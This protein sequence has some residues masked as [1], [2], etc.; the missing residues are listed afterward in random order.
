MKHRILYLPIIEQGLVH[1]LQI[2]TKHGLRDALK[3]Y[4]EVYQLDYLD[5]PLDLLFD[6]VIERIERF[7]PTLLLT[8]LHGVDRLTVAHMK[9]IRSAYPDLICANWS[10]DSWHHSLSSPE[11][12]DLCRTFDL[13][14]I[15]APDELPVYAQNGIRARFWQIAYEEP[16]DPLPETPT[17][18]VVFLGNV[19]SEKRRSLLEFLRSLEGVSVGI[20]GD[21]DR[22]DG[23]N[24]YDFAA[25]EALYKNAT[26]AIADRAYPDQLNYVSNRP[27]HILMAGGAVLLHEHVPKMRELLGI[28]AAIHYDEWETFDDL[29]R[30][31]RSHVQGS[32]FDRDRRKRIVAEGQ[33]YAKRHH[34]YENRV[35]ELFEE[36]LPQIHQIDENERT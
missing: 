2:R 22:S 23:Q 32:A 30:L 3:Q 20:Y 33:S 26:V 35:V 29:D 10:G 18:D 4:G 34:Q 21:W 36:F 28:T 6:E 15:A 24:T 12:L 19:I 9:E 17:Y 13:Q 16:I 25:G 31:I 5:I 1:A 27:I 11:M 8:Q 14:L 7:K